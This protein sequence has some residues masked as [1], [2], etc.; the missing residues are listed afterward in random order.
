M[1]T[2]DYECQ[3]CQHHFEQY[4]A[5]SA[6]KLRR[7]PEC[8]KPKLVRLVGMG[9]G[10]IFKGS[11]FYETD[12]K[13]AG[14]SK[15]ATPTTG[16]KAAASGSDGASAAS[17]KSTSGETGGAGTAGT[18]GKVASSSTSS[19]AKGGGKSKTS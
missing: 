11:G 15:P 9:A 16:E 10:V 2:Y 13:R 14:A 12:Y 7:C 3:A 5:M 18:N 8:G 1:P 4:Q 19:P 17:A 6:K